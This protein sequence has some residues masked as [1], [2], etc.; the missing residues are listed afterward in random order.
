MANVRVVIHNRGERVDMKYKKNFGIIAIVALA[1]ISGLV[2]SGLLTVSKT[3]SSTGTVKAIN[4][5]VYWDS[6]CTQVVNL[7][8]WG[9]LGPGDSVSQ[10]VYVKNG[11]N[12]PMNISLSVSGWSPVGAGSYLGVS[13]DREDAVVAAGGVVQAVLILD[14]SSSITGISDFSFELVIE[15]T[16]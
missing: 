12:A 13:W 1:I 16:G 10:T 8:D 9:I 4:V 2:V 15:G 5:D 3:L 14:V 6:S 7:I 11:G